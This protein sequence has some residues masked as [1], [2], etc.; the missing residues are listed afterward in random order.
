MIRLQEEEPAI[1]SMLQWKLDG[2]KKPLWKEV[3]QESGD[4]KALWGSMDKLGSEGRIV[5][6]AL[7]TRDVCEGTGESLCYL[8]G[9]CS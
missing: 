4:L 1:M 8:P 9:S 6:L 3:S 2:V 7:C 5:V